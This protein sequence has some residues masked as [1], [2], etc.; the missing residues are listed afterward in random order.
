MFESVHCP[1]FGILGLPWLVAVTKSLKT[2]R[3]MVGGVKFTSTYQLSVK[4]SSSSP[5]N[6]SCPIV[7]SVVKVGRLNGYRRKGREKKKYQ[8]TNKQIIII[9]III[10]ITIIIIII[11]IIIITFSP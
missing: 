1:F 4:D 9:I 6:V 11:I 10:I 5:C 8:Q 3:S 7:M 2:L